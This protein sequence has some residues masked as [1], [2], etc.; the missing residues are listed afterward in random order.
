M[1]KPATTTNAF[2]PEIVNAALHKID[3][4]FADLASER[5]A[6][7][8]RCRNIRESISNVYKEAKAQGIPTKELRTLVKIRANEA[9]NQRLYEELETDQQATLAMLASTELVRDLPLWRAAAVDVSQKQ[10]QP[11]P[12]FN[13]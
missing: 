10:S 9:S 1:A 11:K 2:D 3:G 4:F 7:M 5:G 6:S 13:S 12:M 8:S